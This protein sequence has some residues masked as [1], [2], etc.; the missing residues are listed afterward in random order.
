MVEA[1]TIFCNAQPI[2]AASFI[3]ASKLL[4]GSV[5]TCCSQGLPEAGPAEAWPDYRF[6]RNKELTCAD[7]RALDTAQ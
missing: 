2:A 7:T 6:G 1:G 3:L 5:A 4:L